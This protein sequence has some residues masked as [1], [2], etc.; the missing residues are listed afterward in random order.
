[1][2]VQPYLFFD[3]NCEAAIGLYT[4]VLGAQ[5]LM[6][7]R[8]SE[9]PDPIPPGMVPE[10]EENRIMH[11]CLKF[12]ESEVMMSD[13]CQPSQTPFQGFN[14]TVTV[15]GEA[16]AGRVFEAL[17]DGGE[18]RMPLTKTFF[19]AAFGMVT[20]RFGVTWGVVAEG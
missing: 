19:A 18:V 20:D 2:K 12:G 1:M 5:T 16:E 15:A 11:A 4:Q 17:G 14:L 13:G 10:G 3:G 9:S 6:L 8:F 7:M